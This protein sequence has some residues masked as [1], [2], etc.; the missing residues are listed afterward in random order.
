METRNNADQ[1]LDFIFQNIEWLAFEMTEF[2]HYLPSEF[3]SEFIT[4]NPLENFIVDDACCCKTFIDGIPMRNEQLYPISVKH[5]E[6]AK[7]C[8]T[9]AT[10][11][12]SSPSRSNAILIGLFALCDAAS[13]Y[14]SQKQLSFEA[15]AYPKIRAAVKEYLELAHFEPKNVVKWL[16]HKDEFRIL[17]KEIV[18]NATALNREFV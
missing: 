9:P 1:N 10:Q 6:Y 14:N 12:Y 5:Y 4:G 16:T 3:L 7:T 15:F 13:E 8:A 17:N 11:D 2:I 18:K